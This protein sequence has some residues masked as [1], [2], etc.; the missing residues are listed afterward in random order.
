MAPR[1]EWKDALLEIYMCHANLC[2][3]RVFYAGEATNTKAVR[4]CVFQMLT[5][6]VQRINNRGMSGVKA[7]TSVGRQMK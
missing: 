4:G 7:E 2:V 3:I 5:A 6:A 1:G